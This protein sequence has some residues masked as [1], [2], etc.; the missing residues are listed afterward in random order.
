MTPFPHSVDIDAAVA[1]A[2]QFM[3]EHGIRHLPVTADGELVGLLSERDIRLHLGQATDDRAAGKT[4]VRDMHLDDPYVVDLNEPLER[5]LNTMARRHIDSVLVT[6]N[7]RLAGVFT[8]T[9][10][11]RSFARFL[12]DHFRPPGG[13]EAA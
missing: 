6:R 11:C 8:V 10:V 1:A 12:N 5:V 3:R 9:D 4:R 2:R 13:D 7:G